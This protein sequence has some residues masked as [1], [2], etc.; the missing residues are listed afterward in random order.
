MKGLIY[1]SEHKAFVT[2]AVEKVYDKTFES[3][4]LVQP[5]IRN[6]RNELVRMEEETE[7]ESDQRL[8]HS[9]LLQKE[10]MICLHIHLI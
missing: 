9:N 10:Y 7:Y 4:T 8:I 2:E 6:V 1:N 3:K 5:T